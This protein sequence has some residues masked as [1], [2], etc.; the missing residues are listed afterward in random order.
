MTIDW[1]P[2]MNLIESTDLLLAEL[3][4]LQFSS[5]VA[6]VYNPLEYARAPH[7]LYLKKFG[8]GRREVVMFGMNP[9]PWGM[10]QTGVPFGDV[11]SVRDWMGIEAPVGKPPE[12]QPDRPVLGFACKRREASGMRL[13]GWAK[14]R[15]GTP[16]AFFQRFFV[17]NYC[18]LCFFDADGTNRTPDK[19]S[20]KERDALLAA[21]DAALRRTV[22][23]FRPSLVVGVGSFAEGRARAALDGMELTVGRIPHPSPASPQSHHNWGGQVDD[24]LNALGLKY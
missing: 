16:E 22:E 10:V 11:P 24:A 5:P 12:E 1:D 13:W 6:Y 19:I 3:A 8:H 21:C 18:P 4:N 23:H 20:R 2:I 9:G 15:F 17:A 7:E 14:E